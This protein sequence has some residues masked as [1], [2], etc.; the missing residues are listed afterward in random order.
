MLFFIY[1]WQRSCEKIF[2]SIDKT[3]KYSVIAGI[4][5]I[6]IILTPD[7]TGGKLVSNVQN[8]SE[9]SLGREEEGK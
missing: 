4:R 3:A 1:F 2:A 6:R 9:H 7:W 5:K 8:Y